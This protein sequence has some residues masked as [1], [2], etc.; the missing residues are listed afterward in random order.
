MRNFNSWSQ[1]VTSLP[2]RMNRVAGSWHWHLPSWLIKKI[3]VLNYSNNW[4]KSRLIMNVTYSKINWSNL[5]LKPRSR[6]ISELVKL[7]ILWMIV[8]QGSAKRLK[9]IAV[10]ISNREIQK[11]QSWLSQLIN[12][13]QRSNLPEIYR[14]NQA[15]KS[16]DVLTPWKPHQINLCLLC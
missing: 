5:K 8:P 1:S 7:K 2:L 9:Q 16:Q 6:K 14:N 12:T 11:N 3:T 13:Y 10:T 15:Q 4:R